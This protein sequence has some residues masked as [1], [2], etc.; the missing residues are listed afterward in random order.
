MGGNGGII[1]TKAEAP[2]LSLNN[3]AEFEKWQEEYYKLNSSVSFTKD[4]NPNINRYSGSAYEIL[5]PMLRGGKKFEKI[6]KYNKIDIQEYEKLS[7]GISNE[8]SKFKLP[9]PLNLTRCVRDVDYITGTTSSLEDMKKAIGSTYIEK[10]FTS[11]T[12]CSDTMLPFGIGS[13]TQTTLEIYAPQNTKGAYI[14]KMSDHP[15]EFE[16]LIDKN[17]TF[18]IV[19][20]GERDIEV[21]N[22]KGEIHMKKERF[23]K[24]EVIPK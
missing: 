4:D 11:T 10:G 22:F 15:S 17:T 1:N 18:K 3:L 2:N 6:Q 9:T 12:I 14:F 5:N 7:D 24:L 20:A 19:D 23:M 8:L 13:P 16:F 21:R